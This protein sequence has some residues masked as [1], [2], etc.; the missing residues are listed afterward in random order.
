MG[1]ERRYFAEAKIG[2][3]LVWKILRSPPP[4]LTLEDLLRILEIIHI[5]TGLLAVLGPDYPLVEP[6]ELIP[7]FDAP[8]IEYSD[9]PAFSM[10]AFDRELSYQDEGF[11][12]DLLESEGQP[13][14]PTKAAAN[15]MLLRER[16]PRDVVPLMEQELG[17]RPI[18]GLGR[19]IWVLPF[20]FKMDRGHVMSRDGQGLFHLSGVFASFPSDLDGE[21]KRFGKQ[22][23]KFKPGDNHSYAENRLF[24]Y[25][26]LMEQT[27]FPICGERHTSAALFARRLMRRR[28]RFLVKVLGTSDRTIT[29]LT[30]L[31]GKRRLP[32]VEK[33]ALVSA[34]NC[35]SD[36]QQ[37]LEREGFLVERRRRVVILKVYYRQHAYHPDNVLEDRALS[38]TGQEVIHPIT[39][40]ALSVDI[41]CLGQDRLLMLND[42]VRGE[43]EGSIVYRGR[44]QVRGTGD[45][46]RRLKFLAAWLA[47][48]RHILADYSPDNFERASRVIT[49]YLYDPAN[50]EDLERYPELLA[51]V[52]QA[53]SDLRV[54]HR[55]RLLE[56]LVQ[57]KVDASG[58]RLQ[59]SHILI[60][61]VHILSSEGDQL[62]KK[63]PKSLGKLLRIC[64][65]QLENPYL[66]RRYLSKPPKTPRE[67]EVVGEYNLL[68]RLVERFESMLN[69]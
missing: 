11:Q 4:D 40:E 29:T 5:K 26:F 35:P 18:T 16:L 53:L 67:R 10:V 61:L 12:F 36:A 52:K 56:K 54:A 41:L 1:R 31:G 21:I 63:H 13:V 65:R 30:S 60:I 64:R 58:A 45:T 46:K 59:L 7:S 34:A 47:K 8:L 44:E 49:S 25:R 19:Y 32:R 22:I 6:R 37:Q 62:A 24:V 14:D 43:H 15:R 20:L 27:G 68:S 33:V 28:E 23:G 57:G 48:H 38:I 39:G 55:L 50:Q 9:L 17:R 51:E 2:S 69:N 42:I 66:K 3:T